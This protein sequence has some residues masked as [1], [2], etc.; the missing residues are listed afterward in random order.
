MRARKWAFY[1]IQV[2][3]WIISGSDG[4]VIDPAIDRMRWDED[5]L[6]FTASKW[7]LL[8]ISLCAVPT[9]GSGGVLA[10]GDRAYSQSPA[11]IADARA[12]MAARQ[13]MHVREQA[14]CAGRLRHNQQPL[15]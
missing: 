7:E 1:R 11:Y 9:D 6:I 8:E 5:G 3:D 12:R 13:R 2:T 14:A 10:Y 4:D 15:L